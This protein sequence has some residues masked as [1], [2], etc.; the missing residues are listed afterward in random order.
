MV[1][2]GA[3]LCLTAAIGEPVM[4]GQRGANIIGNPHIALI[5]RDQTSVISRVI[6]ISLL[7]QLRF[8]AVPV[9]ERREWRSAFQHGLR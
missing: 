8:F 9:L 4:P 3:W 2:P 1:H 6:V 7:K 5:V